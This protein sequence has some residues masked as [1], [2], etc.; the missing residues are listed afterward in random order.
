MIIN[1]IL[2]ILL[3]ISGIFFVIFSNNRLY[4]EVFRRNDIKIFKN[5]IN[6]IDKIHINPRLISK[7]LKFY[8]FNYE[9]DDSISVN[10]YYDELSDKK[11]SFVSYKESCD[12]KVSSYC[13]YYSTKLANKLIDLLNEYNKQSAV[14]NEKEMVIN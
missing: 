4:C 1:C 9:L 5:I 7:E 12:C 3:I 14:D 10:L 8:S 2:I 6:N 11:Y 13:R